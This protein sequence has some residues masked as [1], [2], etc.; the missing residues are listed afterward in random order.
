MVQVPDTETEGTSRQRRPRLLQLAAAAVIV[1]GGISLLP[2]PES[3]LE[4][5]MTDATTLDTHFELPQPLEPEQVAESFMAAWMAGDS[6]AA[7]SL[8][9]PGTKF[10]GFEPEMFPALHRWY[11]AT[12]WEFLE[13]ECGPHGFGGA[14]CD[15]FYENKLTRAFGVG[16]LAGSFRPY[17]EGGRI[18]LVNDRFHFEDGWTDFRDWLSTNH[19]DDFERMYEQ[20]PN[21][22]HFT[23]RYVL[24]DQV[25]LELWEHS[26]DEFVEF[27]DSEGLATYRGMV[28]TI[29]E[30][31]HARVNEEVL[32]AGIEM[33]FPPGSGDDSLLHPTTEE[34]AVVYIE[35]AR[36]IMSETLA[37]LRAIPPPEAIRFY[38]E[39]MYG[40]MEQFATGVEDPNAPPLDIFPGGLWI[41]QVEP[42]LSLVSCTFALG[43]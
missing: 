15:Y 28:R 7:A 8:F 35:T 40:L 24:I 25:A 1:F 41:H 10:H 16:P 23:F 20:H 37:E 2:I 30:A 42:E 43:R 27:V 26:T 36:R 38:F 22:Q 29:C 32:A 14:G 6:E 34:G 33:V 21:P 11:E 3:R 39:G 13:A 9:R 31:A 5:G 17:V 12:G 4:D 19:P 18:W